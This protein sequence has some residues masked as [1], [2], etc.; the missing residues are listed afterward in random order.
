MEDH[1]TPD[2][3]DFRSLLNYDGSLHYGDHLQKYHTHITHML[4]H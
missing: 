2:S 3:F 4:S 1:F